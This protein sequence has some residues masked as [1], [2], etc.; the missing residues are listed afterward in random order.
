M[1]IARVMIS[2]V[3]I[4]GIL[5]IYN[6]LINNNLFNR[7]G[8][9]I[10]SAFI[11]SI[12]YTSLVSI[13]KT[14]QIIA[15]L[16]GLFLNAILISKFEN[17]DTILILVEI[18]I[19]GLVILILELLTTF[20]IHLIIGDYDVN[21]FTYLLLISSIM[22]LLIFILRIILKNRTIKLSEFLSRFRGINIIILNLFVFFMFI[23]ILAVN[24]LIQTHIV[25]QVTILG[26]ILIG[27][28]CYFYVYLYKTLNVKKK[29]EIKKSFNPLINDLMGKVKANEHEY[30]NH[31]NT[32]WS[33][34]QVSD[35]MDVKDKIK[36][37]ISNIVDEGEEFSM[38]LNIDNTIV[39]AV[40]Y[41]KGQ[42][43]EKLGVKYNYKVTS[44]L[45][46]I[47]LDNSELTVVLSNLLNNA[48]EATSMIKNKEVSICID[49]D[50]KNYIINVKNYSE[51]VTPEILSSI[52]K[53]GYTT[54]G[55]GRGYGLYNVKKIVD[56]HKGK[57]QVSLE[58]D[59][60]N[61]SVI[62]PKS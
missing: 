37:Y 46:D 3:E 42:R 26:L 50:T 55:E 54:K 47:P 53:M 52:F 13:Y 51:G 44:D 18:T 22:F 10:V 20:V 40:L 23:K 25:V 49:E 8:V 27:I 15:L 62:F 17:K 58:E 9:N 39:K 28:N 2:F 32:I 21:T 61:I 60:V 59:I 43:A 29:K 57:I 33:I 6:I 12:L 31:L 5:L 35:P 14:D 4:L 30:K 36:E 41:N 1:D 38:L 56:K 45:S 16:G 19:S 48:I 7:L 11:T 34:A 24:D